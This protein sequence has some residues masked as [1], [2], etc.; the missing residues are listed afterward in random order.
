MNFNPLYPLSAL[1]AEELAACM[2][3]ASTI[4]T[5]SECVEHS[6]AAHRIRADIRSGA[7]D[8]RDLLRWG[9]FHRSQV[10]EMPLRSEWEFPLALI[11][12]VLAAT[13]VA[14]SVQLIE[15]IATSQA[16]QSAWLSALS[17][18][19]LA[20]YRQTHTEAAPLEQ[21][22][23]KLADLRISSTACTSG[24]VEQ[25]FRNESSPPTLRVELSQV[26]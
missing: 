14:G 7:V 12:T 8:G 3:T 15:A 22:L 9:W 1:E 25:R 11:V 6:A 16:P 20:R 4:E 19:L 18:G 13:G 26:A 21:R 24:E 23:M 2:L 10:C 5:Y 17:R